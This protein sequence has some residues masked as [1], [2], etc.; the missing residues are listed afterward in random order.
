MDK[1]KT[2]DV[3]NLSKTCKTY[4]QDTNL[5]AHR[6]KHFDSVTDGFQNIIEAFIEICDELQETTLF[7][8]IDSISIVMQLQANFEIHFGVKSNYKPL[9]PY[10]AA[11]KGDMSKL[12]GGKQ[13]VYSPYMHTHALNHYEL[14]DYFKLPKLVTDA[15]DSKEDDETHKTNTSRLQIK[16]RGSHLVYD[17]NINKYKI[18]SY[19][20]PDKERVIIHE[21]DEFKNV[22][23]V[24]PPV[25]ELVAGLVAQITSFFER[26]WKARFMGGGLVKGVKSIK[27]KGSTIT[28]RRVYIDKDTKKAYV[29]INKA[30]VLLSAIKGKYRYVDGGLGN[31][32]FVIVKG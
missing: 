6:D 30:K 32:E 26:Q 8:R 28:K 15:R 13:V 3:Y 1:L 9:H 16:A 23:W 24:A 10:D 14:D 17:F 5:Q 21:I 18:K 2:K 7:C 31:R 25:K 20:D 27:D 22:S 19:I 4:N 29:V 12:P 11:G